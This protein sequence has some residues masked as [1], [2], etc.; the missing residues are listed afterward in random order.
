MVAQAH[1]RVAVAMIAIKIAL[2]VLF[3]LMDKISV[4]I[5]AI[6]CLLA[7]IAW[8]ALHTYFLPFYSVSDAAS[9]LSTSSSCCLVTACCCSPILR[10]R[11]A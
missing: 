6:G 3:T 1:G 5:L 2:T 11:C 9:S 4:V 10:H 7:G 8:F